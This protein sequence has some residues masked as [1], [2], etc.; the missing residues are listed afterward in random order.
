MNTAEPLE[1]LRVF[2]TDLNIST[3][4]VVG[5]DLGYHQETP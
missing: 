5:M 3:I 4:A 1:Q 2:A